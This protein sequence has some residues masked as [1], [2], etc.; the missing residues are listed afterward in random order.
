[1]PTDMSP[2]SPSDRRKSSSSSTSCVAH[3]AEATKVGIPR[4]AS[5]VKMTTMSAVTEGSIHHTVMCVEVGISNTMPS[6]PPLHDW[7]SRR[8]LTSQPR[9]DR[10]GTMMSTREQHLKPSQAHCRPSQHRCTRLL[11]HQGH[12]HR[13]QTG[14]STYTPHVIVKEYT[15]L[16][17]F[18]C[19]LRMLLALSQRESRIE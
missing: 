7:H 2:A 14:R 12:H 6:T 19:Y 4:E 13:C 10:L 3:L 15:L 16:C 11:Y 9:L 8:L 18:S 17:T 1:M 5:T